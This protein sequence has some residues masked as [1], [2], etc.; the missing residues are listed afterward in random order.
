MCFSCFFLLPDNLS[1]PAVSDMTISTKPCSTLTETMKL[2]NE[3]QPRQDGSSRT[4]DRVKKNQVNQTKD[5]IIN[6]HSQGNRDKAC[7]EMA[8][9]CGSCGEK[10][11]KLS[12]TFDQNPT[13][14]E[15]SKIEEEYEDDHVPGQTEH[16]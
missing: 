7:Y 11:Q 6:K 10:D 9:Q 14:M 4:Q 13:N 16:V 2:L 8:F 12:I 5:V 15:V 3:T 1:S